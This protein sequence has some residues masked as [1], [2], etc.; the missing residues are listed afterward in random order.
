MFDNFKLAIS[1]TFKEWMDSFNALLSKLDELPIPIA[2]GLTSTLKY[3]KF[4]NGTVIMWGRVDHGTRYPCNVAWTRGFLSS[5]ISIDF[6]I[7]LVNSNPTVVAM[8]EADK[9]KDVTACP[10][11]VTYTTFTFK[12]WH[13]AN[14]EAQSNS[15][16]CNIIVIGEWK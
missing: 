15:K 11:S 4:A 16:V 8:A 1:K 5:A 10:Y 7:A 13:V 2:F 9:W 12:Y 14:D 3:L 6:P